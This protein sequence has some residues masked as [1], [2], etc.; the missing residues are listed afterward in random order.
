MKISMNWLKDYLEI[1]GLTAQ[2]IADRLT[3]AGLE[4][5]SVQ[6]LGKALKNVVVGKIIE[7]N[8]HPN[9]DRLTVCQVQISDHDQRQ[10]VCGAKNHRAGDK[11]VVALV[12]AVLP[13]DF[14]I[15]DSKIRDVESKGM[16]CSETELGLKK[17]AE[18]ILILPSDAPVGES[19]AS[20]WGL[21]D[22]VIEINVTPNRADCLSH[23]GLAREIAALFELKL[24]EIKPKFKTQKKFTKSTIKVELRDEAQCPRYS[25][26]A[27]RGVKVGPSPKWLQ[28]RLQAVDIN[29][30]NNVVDV[31]NFVM[32]ELGQ[33]LHAFDV[34]SIDGSVIV[35][36]K[37]KA[38]EEFQSLDGSKLKLSGDE[39]TIR[40]GAK[41]VAL[42]GVVGGLNS[43]VSADTTDLFI[44]SAHFAAESVRRTARRLGIQTDSAYRFSRGTD[45][46]GVVLALDRCCE[47]IAQ[48]AGGEIAEDFY[49]EYPKRIK[50][51]P[52]PITADYVAQRLGYEVKES[53]LKAILKRLGCEVDKGAKT[54]QV[55]VPDYR[56]DLHDKTDLVEEYARVKGYDLI[57][58]RFPA[59]VDQPL[60]HAQEFV[61]EDLLSSRLVATGF[62]QAINFGFVSSAWQKKV[63]GESAVARFGAVGLS[64]PETAV[65]I[66]NP[67]NEDLDV[68]RVSLL[69]HLFRNVLH[70]VRYGCELGRIFE[71]GQV[72]RKQNEDYQQTARLALAAWG[73]KS[74]LWNRDL[75]RPVIYDL[76]AAVELVLESLGV[77]PQSWSWQS[78][79]S[80]LVP[81]L[82]HPGQCASLFLEGRQVGV[83]GTLHPNWQADEK[84][85]PTVAFG[86]F[87][88]S[89]LMR[90]QPRALKIQSPSKYPIVERDLALV[91]RKDL[92]VSEVTKEMKKIAGDVLRG[93]EVFDVF[94]GGQ[95][96]EDQRSVAIRM[97]FQDQNGTFNEAQ[98]SDLQSRLIEG[99]K[100]KLGALIR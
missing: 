12:G 14:A 34:R 10:I 35:I 97:L 30:I 82:F 41:A 36:E 6:D 49:D 13:G 38:N 87:D 58:E 67:L 50:R 25:G 68:M 84:I 51:R 33:P 11:V 3:S 66:K 21:D 43:G 64:L 98:L 2:S 81:S 73:Q 46:E 18:G 69:P 26:R 20:Y 29:T 86:E 22:A 71:M 56:A 89:A 53:D 16:L 40:D 92:K 27:I 65:K 77:G 83:I 28:Q 23:Y 7:L 52:V 37:A 85:R 100:T 63:L 93:T 61:L 79:K 15:K 5:E 8:R 32:L 42:A 70:N 19:F 80:E 9:A 31:T 90:G 39:L 96:A 24:K 99:L 4:V 60:R 75:A 78:L 72:F 48:V 91:I 62:G 59:L 76:K 47:L 55:S 57:P 54:L 95:L 94:Q 74:G 44:E 88:F 1:E 45:P 17:E